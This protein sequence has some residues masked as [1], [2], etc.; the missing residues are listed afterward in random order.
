VR[1][2]SLI[3]QDDAPTGTFAD[4]VRKRN[5]EL[6]EWNPANGPPP[7]AP[8]SFDAVFVFGGGMHVDQEDEHPWLR[9]ENSLIKGLLAERVPVLGV[10][11]GGQLIAKAAGAHVGPAPHEEIGWHEVVMT[12]E[13]RTDPVFAGVP[14][15]FDAFQWHQYAFDLPEGAVPLGRSPAGLQAYRLGD[16][17]WGLQ[18][19]AEVTRKIVEGWLASDGG[20][21][22]IDL[23]PIERWAE[24][25]RGLA[26]RFL[27]LATRPRRSHPV[28]TPAS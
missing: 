16:S 6:V 1:V 12:P 14:E 15:R 19:H 2:L 3:H 18:F 5:G 24:L 13:A 17:A 11:L 9:D 20:R 4:A 21:R 8:E 28:A 22:E 25:G 27:E 7:A 23:A 26:D 10:C